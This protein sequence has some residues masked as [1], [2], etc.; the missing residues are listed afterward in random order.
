[1]KKI[2]DT[3]VHF[4]TGEDLARIGGDLPYTLPAPH[5]LQSYLDG[6]IGQ[7]RKPALINHVHISILPDSENVFR[8]FEELAELQRQTPRVTAGLNWS[9][10]SRPTHI[11]PPANA[12]P[13]HR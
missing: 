5:P 7:G 6:L 2:I 10:P 9:E 8:S 12:L 13:T 1:M 4:Y 11:T 3:H